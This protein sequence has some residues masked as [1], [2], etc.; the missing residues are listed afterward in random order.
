MTI[1]AIYTT[2]ASATQ[3]LTF[4]HCQCGTGRG[5]CD[6]CPLDHQIKLTGIEHVPALTK[7]GYTAV[8]IA[9]GLGITAY[10][11]FEAGARLRSLDDVD[12]VADTIPPITEIERTELIKTATEWV[13]TPAVEMAARWGIRE[14]T[15]E[16]LRVTAA[17]VLADA[18][19][20]SAG[21]GA[22]LAA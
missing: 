3:T 19:E 7:A 6:L 21:P 1:T 11:A 16:Q 20:N 4:T 15:A 10:A 5:R 12:A 22:R 8:E 13:A 17:Q 2:P 14:E 18:E 9:D